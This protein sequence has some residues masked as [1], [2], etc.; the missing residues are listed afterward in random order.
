MIKFEELKFKT[1]SG[2]ILI[3]SIN[4]AKLL[5]KQLNKIFNQSSIELKNNDEGTYFTK[6]TKLKF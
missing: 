3:L 1:S 4:D 2:K 5:Y 6:F